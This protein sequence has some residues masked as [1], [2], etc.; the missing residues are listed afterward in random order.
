MDLFQSVVLLII[1]ITATQIQLKSQCER[2]ILGGLPLG[3][4]LTMTSEQIMNKLSAFG[5]N[6][7]MMCLFI[8]IQAQMDWKT[9]STVLRVAMPFRTRLNL[10]HQPKK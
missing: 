9:N 8:A 10:L 7:L 6:K 1:T 2:S 3:T 4:K 5:N